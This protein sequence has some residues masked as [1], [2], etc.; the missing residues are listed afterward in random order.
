MILFKNLLFFF[1]LTVTVNLG[2]PKN[3][4]KKINKNITETFQLSDF[5]L[6]TK[7]I[8]GN[9]AG[10][11]PSVF[12]GNFFEIV[13][14][15]SVYGYAY[16]GEAASKTDTFLYLVLLDKDLIIKNS[17]VLVYREDYGGEIG[18]KRWLRQFNGKTYN[19]DLKYGDDVM[20]ISGATISVRSMTS[21]I[22]DLLTSI[23]I[24][25]SKNIL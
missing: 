24:L 1:V 23:R 19:D 3:L 16:V 8:N 11:L 22:N 2:I 7:E 12:D 21:A 5:T 10:E 4:E 17:K 13:S 25:H 20:A 6:K 15:N 9:I 18:S 14:Q